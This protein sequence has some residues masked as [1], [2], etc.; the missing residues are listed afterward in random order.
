M[1]GI[2]KI[3]N[4]DNGKMYVGQAV[5]IE[6][7]WADHRR[8][9]NHNNHDNL[10][11]QNSWNLHGENSFNFEIIELCQ[12]EQL[13]EKEIFWID[14]L[15]SY[16]YFEDSNGYNLNLGG[17]GNRQ[18]R[19]VLR[20]D[21]DG[22]FLDEWKSPMDVSISIGVETQDIYGCANKKF[23]YR[24]GYIWIWKEDYIDRLS[25]DWYLDRKYYNKV[26]QYDSDG[27]LIASFNSK[28]EAEC[29]LGYNI[30]PCL[31]HATMTCHGFIFVYENENIIVDNDYCKK[32]FSLLNNI[33]NHPFYKVDMFGEIVKYYNCQREAVEEGYSEK[34]ISECLRKLRNKHKGYLWIYVDEYNEDCKDE[35]MALYKTPEVKVD[36]PILQIKDGVIVNRYEHLRDI[37]NEF[38]KSSVSNVCKGR[39]PQYK[40]FVWKYEGYD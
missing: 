26:L 14:K 29:T 28:S 38:I 27:I 21:M 31:S 1:T 30:G 3:T 36:L 7:R 12:E 18:L 39:K 11:L 25:L 33:R 20:F 13:D 24:N 2:Y 35:Y 32:A 15:R 23:K 17:Q 16:R 6:K 4:L 8:K 22:N 34:M 37:P 40:G 19:P 9:L 10:Y 5:D